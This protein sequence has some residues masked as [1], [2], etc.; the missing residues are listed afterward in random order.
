MCVSC[1]VF[2]VVVVIV[3]IVCSFES[4]VVGFVWGWWCSSSCP[5]RSSRSWQSKGGRIDLVVSAFG[6]VVLLRLI[7]CYASTTRG[8]IVSIVCGRLSPACMSLIVR[9]RSCVVVVATVRVDTGVAL[10][11]VRVV[12]HGRVV[13]VG[14]V[15]IVCAATTSIASGD[16]TTK[17]SIWDPTTKAFV[18]DPSTKVV[19]V[20]GGTL[21][22]TF[23]SGVVL[24]VHIVCVAVWVRV[25][26]HRLHYWYVIAMLVDD[27][28]RVSMLRRCRFARCGT[29]FRC[30]LRVIGRGIPG[31]WCLQGMTVNDVGCG[32]IFGS[33][34]YR[35]LP[36]CCSAH[37]CRYAW[38]VRAFVL[39]SA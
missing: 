7:R 20:G 31:W 26:R 12:L 37:R 28:N 36:E 2:V 11:I 39:V 35:G 24:V 14:G 38:V 34:C 25:G 3:L 22:C 23:R 16:A 10:W 9:A 21:V 5:V 18:G 27:G 13:A 15:G 32:G 4:M 6:G 8:I 19:V 33:A 17:T 30:R 1:V 29:L